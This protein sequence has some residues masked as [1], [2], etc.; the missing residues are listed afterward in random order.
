MY[1]IPVTILL[2]VYN[3]EKYLSLA[4]SSV[5]AQDFTDFELLIIDDG[6]RDGSEAIIRSFT[7]P[8]IRFVKNE[9]NLGLVRTLN[10]GMDLAKGNYIARM[11]A[12]DVM[13]PAR[14]GSQFDYLE[15]H[16]SVAAVASVVDLIDQEG[17]FLGFWKEDKNNSTVAAIRKSLPK[18]NCIAHPSVMIRTGV[19]KEFR[20]EPAG[21]LVEDY[22]LWLRMTA[23]GYQ[24]GKLEEVLLHHRILQS[25]LTRSNSYNVYTLNGKVLLRFFRNQ[26]FKKKR[27]LFVCRTF[28]F[29]WLNLAK[30]MIYAL[31][32]NR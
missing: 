16:D 29:G 10:K 13:D 9:Q 27:T 6:S 12:D 30:G 21:K 4:I 7:D 28:I 15:R 2:P 18:Y 5:L 31:T 14:I 11:D 19:L 17:N 20:Y 26:P 8:R 25:S 1:E 23:A 32:R 22:D 24:I 3:G